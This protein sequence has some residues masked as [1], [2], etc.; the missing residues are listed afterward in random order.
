M[1]ESKALDFPVSATEL[2]DL[3]DELYPPRCIAPGQPLEEAIRYAGSRDL[4]DMLINWR[5]H[6]KE[7]DLSESIDRGEFESIS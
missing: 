2:V 6:E 5:D 4:I 1:S 3:L 7:P